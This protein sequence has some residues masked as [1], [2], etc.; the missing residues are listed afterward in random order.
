MFKFSVL[1][2]NFKEISENQR[3]Q[4]RCASA[5]LK[6]HLTFRVT[7][8]FQSSTRR[9][10]T[11]DIVEPVVPTKP[12]PRLCAT[13]STK[14]VYLS[15]IVFRYEAANHLTERDLPS[16]IFLLCLLLVMVNPRPSHRLHLLPP[17]S[18]AFITRYKYMVR[19]DLNALLVAQLRADLLYTFRVR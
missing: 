13:A 9:C 19:V 1:Q 16:P 7:P 10:A 4:C 2:K 6:P 12:D 8:L 11:S 14:T 5:S 17:A 15:P 18:V 3:Y